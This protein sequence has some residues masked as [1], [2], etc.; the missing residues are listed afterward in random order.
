MHSMQKWKKSHEI[1]SS[2]QH[3]SDDE[4][5]AIFV[6][7]D[8]NWNC[9]YKWLY[10]YIYWYIFDPILV[11]T[12]ALAICSSLERSDGH[13]IQVTVTWEVTSRWPRSLGSDVTWSDVIWKILKNF[14]SLYFGNLGNFK[15][16]HRKFFFQVTITFSRID[17]HFFKWRSDGRSQYSSNV[18]KKYVV[19]DIVLLEVYVFY[20]TM[21]QNSI[22]GSNQSQGREAPEG[23]IW[24]LTSITQQLF[25]L[26]QVINNW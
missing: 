1:F 25:C 12:M 14:F 26:K 9:Y 20:L 23:F 16:F 19:W 8:P 10:F 7:G 5:S 22:L 15:R 13:C 6:Q 3:F 21:S 4:I 18:P 11:K 2:N 24:S 17:R